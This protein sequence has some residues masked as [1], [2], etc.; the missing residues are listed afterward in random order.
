MMNNCLLKTTIKKIT[1][2]SIKKYIKIPKKLTQIGQRAYERR[3]ALQ[4]YLQILLKEASIHT[5]KV[6]AIKVA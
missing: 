5:A 3:K 2:Y 4:Q 1:F 6:T